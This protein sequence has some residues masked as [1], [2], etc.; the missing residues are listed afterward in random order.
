MYEIG[1]L[2][3]LGCNYINFVVMFCLHTVVVALMTII[4]FT[5][6]FAIFSDLANQILV[7]SLKILATK[8]VMLDL[9]FI[10]FNINLVLM[11]SIL[12]LIISLL[13]TIVP[14]ILIKQIKPIT[15]IKA[16]E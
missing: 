11:N 10:Y 6:G 9:E 5:L 14:T 4:F 15:I 12:V 1:V 2:K 16:K 8:S 13:S 7:D 3:A